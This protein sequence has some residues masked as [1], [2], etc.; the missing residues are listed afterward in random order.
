[1]NKV[2]E[3]NIIEAIEMPIGTEFEVYRYKRDRGFDKCKM[4]T[5]V[6]LNENKDIC[7]CGTNEEMPFMVNSTIKAKFIPIQKPISFQEAYY[8]NKLLIL[9]LD[10][11]IKEYLAES[12][13]DKYRTMEDIVGILRKTLSNRTLIKVLFE[14][15]FY[16]EA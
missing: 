13:D 11:E 16:A 7:W 6:Y 14:G 9:E 2:K 5:N 3:L 15:K 10:E 8:Q 12:L 1:M 4:I